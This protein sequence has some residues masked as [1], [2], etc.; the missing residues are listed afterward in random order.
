MLL[1]Y[2]DRV[3]ERLLN[4]YHHEQLLYAN[5]VGEH[6]PDPPKHLPTM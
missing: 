1:A 2:E 5:G 6:P 4:R 3:L